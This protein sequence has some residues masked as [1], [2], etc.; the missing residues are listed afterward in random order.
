MFHLFDKVYLEFDTKISAGIN[1]IVISERFA[2]PLGIEPEAPNLIQFHY[3]KTVGELIGTDKAFTTELDFFKGLKLLGDANP[4]PLVVYCD[5]SAFLHLFISWNKSILENVSAADLWKIFRFSIEK[6][7]Y[8][9]KFSA[10][11]M[12]FVE[13]SI[14]NW[15]IEEFDTK[16][17]DLDPDKDRQWNAQIIPNLG[18]EVLLA[19]YL[20]TQSSAISD[21]LKSKILL[22]TT[23]SIQSELYEAKFELIVNYQNKTLHDILSVSDI[24][25]LEELFSHPRTSIFVEQRLWTEDSVLYPTGNGSALNINAISDTD[26][27]RLVDGFN[28]SRVELGGIGA[29]TPQSDIINRLPWVVRGSMTDQELTSLLVNESFIGSSMAVGDVDIK[30][31]NIIFIDWILKLHRTANLSVLSDI[32]V[33]V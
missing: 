5:K 2:A 33:A 23:R 25:S 4:S 22:L 7:T 10:D 9:S 31:I 15:S 16:F 11:Y 3:A 8:L 20:L 21:A 27:L 1:R 19:S 24:Q 12:T 28:L 18:I 29:S 26:M 30:N 13:Y 17:N 32:T 14:A 6:E